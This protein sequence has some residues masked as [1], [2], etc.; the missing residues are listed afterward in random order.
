[1]SDYP[2]CTEDD[3]DDDY[4]DPLPKVFIQQANSAFRHLQAFL[5]QHTTNTS[6][7]Y[8]LLTELKRDLLQSSNNAITQT[9]IVRLF[10]ENYMMFFLFYICMINILLLFRVF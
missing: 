2:S 6:N 7:T 9:H 4:G 5:L 1:M 8:R 3:E 10:S